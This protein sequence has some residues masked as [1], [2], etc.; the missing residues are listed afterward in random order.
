MRKEH[1]ELPVTEYLR[2]DIPTFRC[3]WSVQQLLDTLRAEKD[4]LGEQILYFYVVDEQN[5]L[6][7]IVAARQLLLASPEARLQEVMQ[8][9]VITLPST[10]SLADACEFFILYKLL[11]LPVVDEKKHLLGV[12]EVGAFTDEAFDFS[13]K[14]QADDVFQW[15]GVRVSQLRNASPFRAFRFRFPWLLATMI[16]G[17]ACAVITTYFEATV[18]QALILASFLAL[19]LGLS[20]SV[21]VQAMTVTVQNLHGRKRPARD[22]FSRLGRELVTAGLLGASCGLLVG[23]LSLALRGTALM[24]AAI[25]FSIFLSVT[26]ASLIGMSV[27]ALLHMAKRDP[28]IASGPI[29]LAFSDVL[30]LLF[31][32]NIARMLL[33]HI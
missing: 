26:C 8:R 29:A 9:R 25:G 28:K 15:I 30:T 2:T 32:F 33:R 24:S 7:G 19:V 17:L 12:I 1:F 14:Q 18:S 31:Y 20:E 13:E 3:D 11:A 23:L 4:L 27:P 21:S 6:A 16:G 10:A 5:H 22:F